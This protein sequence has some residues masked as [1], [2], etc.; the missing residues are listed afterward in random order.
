MELMAETSSWNNGSMIQLSNYGNSYTTDS[1]D[2]WIP[3]LSDYESGYATSPTL[4]TTGNTSFSV[5]FDASGSTNYT[6]LLQAMYGPD[7]G[8]MMVSLDGK[9]LSDVDLSSEHAMEGWIDLT[10][11]NLTKGV[12]KLTFNST[13]NGSVS[14]GYLITAPTSEVENNMNTT[15]SLLAEYR[16]KVVYEYA[17]STTTWEAGTAFA[18]TGYDGKGV[19]G[20]LYLDASSM[21]G[22]D[23]VADFNASSGEVI[24]ISNGTSYELDHL[25][26][27]AAPGSGYALTVSVRSGSDGVDP[28]GTLEVVASN[29][30]VIASRPLTNLTSSYQNVTIDL[31]A[32]TDTNGM[33]VII[34]SYNQSIYLDSVVLSPAGGAASPTTDMY[35]P[36]S[37]EFQIRVSADTGSLN[38]SP[39]NETMVIDNVTYTGKMSGDLWIFN[40]S[41]EAGEHMVK[42]GPGSVYSFDI[43]PGDDNG[44]LNG[45]T[46]LFTSSPA[47]LTY[48]WNSST[49][50]TV[51]VNSENGTWI[52]L[53]ESYTDLWVATVNGVQL[54]HIEVDGI[55]S[56]YYVPAGNQTVVLTFGGQ[57]IYD[58]MQT[59]MEVVAVSTTAIIAV[60]IY[61]RFVWSD[62]R[63]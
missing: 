19:S 22:G 21:D 13:G 59:G 5:N 11:S 58:K 40:V 27:S 15:E 46:S 16:D 7:A 41:L 34:S 45:T 52:L 2:Y 18:W 23:K 4:Y 30:S 29:G 12:H 25:F 10:A 6:F 32:T 56:A 51:Q 50:Y 35:I 26:V 49:Q 31:N 48:V 36:Y 63:K 3:S 1:N 17:A 38:G 62:H 43:S 39:Y 61:R 37:G 55:V 47:T 8:S 14:L 53:S 44:T 20:T 42:F 28:G 9:E 57:E 24:L 54:P 60:K 33:R